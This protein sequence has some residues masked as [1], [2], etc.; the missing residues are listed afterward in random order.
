[1]FGARFEITPYLHAVGTYYYGFVNITDELNVDEMKHRGFQ[2][3]LT[4]GL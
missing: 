3:Y 4:Y 1:M 2:F